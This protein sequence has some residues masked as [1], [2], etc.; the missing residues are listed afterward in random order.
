MQFV[1]PTFLY[2]LG[3]VA[4][5][6]I[7]HLFNLVRPKKVVFSNIQFL[8]EVELKSSKKVKLRQLL[9][10]I[11]RIIFIVAL[12]L[13][14]AQPFL[15][16]NQMFSENDSPIVSIYLDNSESMSSV[17]NDETL[18]N[19]SIK[20]ISK[21]VEKYPRNTK[22]QLLDNDFNAKSNFLHSKDKLIDY[23]TEIEYSTVSRSATTVYEKQLS[24]LNK[25]ESKT[26]QIIWFSDFQ[27]PFFESL[28]EIKKD[29]SIKHFL[30]NTRS[31]AAANVMIDSVYLDVQFMSLNSPNQLKIKL[32]NVGEN[33]VEDLNVKLVLDDVQVAQ[34]TVNISS[35]SNEELVLQF[36]IGEEGEHLGKV[37]IDDNLGLAFDNELYF[38]LNSGVSINIL[39][40]SDSTD[41]YFSK[42]YRNESKFNFTHLNV[43]EID[44]E[45]LTKQDFIILEELN[46]IPNS[47]ISELVTNENKS[48]L[49]IPNAEN[50]TKDLNKLMSNYEVAVVNSTSEKLSIEVPD[51][52]SPLFNDVFTKVDSKVKMPQ[53]ISKFDFKGNHSS[54]LKFV[55]GKTALL[56]KN[57]FYVFASSFTKGSDFI[58][59]SFI[60]PLMY[61]LAMLSSSQNQYIYYTIDDNLKEVKIESDSIKQQYILQNGDVNITPEQFMVNNNL[62][63]RI[64]PY[65]V[66]SGFY[67][68]KQDDSKIKTIAFNRELSEGNITPIDEENITRFSDVFV[69]KDNNPSEIIDELNNG[70]PLWRYFLYLALVA[71]LVE[72]LLIRFYKS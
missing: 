49:V 42:L 7:I 71:L 45:Q 5:P 70:V 18:L 36:Q 28:S 61:K 62:R 65:E 11:T 38:T 48:V 50:S 55:N 10:L 56:Q 33:N 20:E 67:E 51:T 58:N 9:I 25:E 31:K 12:V 16:S 53:L 44:Y 1:Y 4:I 64:A 23:L 3:L 35:N 37:I 59:H 15:S 30:F 60:V 27:K 17:E 54:P 47:L 26:K 22:F 39:S 52:K 14:F 72:I 29:T 21:L 19:N 43:N 6:I 68:L 57:N 2:A 46:Q 66:K 40:I 24:V 34:S 13:V 63:F 32:K 69:G 41:S 8:K